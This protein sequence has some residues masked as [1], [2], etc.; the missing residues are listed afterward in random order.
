MATCVFSQLLREGKL[1]MRMYAAPLDRAVEDQAQ[2]G[3]GRA[4]GGPSFG[5]AHS[6]CLPTARWARTPPISSTPSSMSRMIGACLAEDMLPMSRM[7]Q[8]LMRADAAGLQVCTH[9][10]G[11]AA[12]STILDLYAGR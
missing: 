6:R 5:S 2:L 10:I 12:I 3:I 1:T 8:R 7:R 9:A 4:F 11:D